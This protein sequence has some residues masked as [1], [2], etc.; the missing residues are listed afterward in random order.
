[1]KWFGKTEGSRND[2]V[3]RK[4]KNLR[5]WGRE[6]R[7]FGAGDHGER[8]CG[9]Q[10][11]DSGSSDWL[12]LGPM[13]TQKG[14][15]LHLTPGCVSPVMSLTNCGNIPT[16]SWPF[17]YHHLRHGTVLDIRSS[18]LPSPG[19]RSYGVLTEHDSRKHSQW[20]RLVEGYKG[21]PA[22]AYLGRAL[23]EPKRH[24]P[25]N[26]STYSVTNITISPELRA[27]CLDIIVH[28]IDLEWVLVMAAGALQTICALFMSRRRFPS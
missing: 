24:R 11:R 15:L 21:P 7:R 10:L 20:R 8:S 16:T 13:L 1:M 28:V 6:I 12:K 22:S 17:R 18:R 23:E 26:P 19:E 3:V 4:L 25:S 9:I 5:A 2:S 27:K 14:I